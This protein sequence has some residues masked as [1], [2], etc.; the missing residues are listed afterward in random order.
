MKEKYFKKV[1]I[2]KNNL[3]IIFLIVIENI[4]NFNLK[5]R[6]NCNNKENNK[7]LNYILN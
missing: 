2:I 4:S 1:K 7:C 6:N 5:V 3:R